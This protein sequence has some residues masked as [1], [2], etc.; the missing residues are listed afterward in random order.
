MHPLTPALSPHKAEEGKDEGAT[1]Q[2]PL[3]PREVAKKA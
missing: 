2:G 1:P 3:F